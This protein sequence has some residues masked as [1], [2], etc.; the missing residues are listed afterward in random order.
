M[1]SVA[2]AGLGGIVAALS[3]FVWYAGNR[4]LVQSWGIMYIAN[5]FVS[6]ITG[7]FAYMA[8]RGGILKADASASALNPYAIAVI[9]GVAGLWSR[10][11]LF[12][13]R[14]LAEQRFGRTGEGKDAR[15][16]RA[17]VIS[18]LKL[19]QSERQDDEQDNA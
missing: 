5:P 4:E 18:S 3:S 11:I 15:P 12:K 19:T 8:I 16:Q 2:S 10:H 9:A 13:L 17:R 1:I 6:M 14:E 7:M